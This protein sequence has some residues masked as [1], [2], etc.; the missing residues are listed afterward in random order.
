MANRKKY[1]WDK[2]HSEFTRSNIS[3]RDLAKKHDVRYSYLAQK[4]SKEK[5]FEQRDAVQ[6]QAREAVA[7]ELVR[8]AE[9]QNSQLSKIVCKDGEQHMKRSV[10][11]GDKLYTLFEAA[12]TAMT[13]GNLRE[14]RT[15]IDAWVVLDNQ[16]RK[17]HNIDEKADKPLVNINVLGAL[18]SREEMERSRSKA[19]VEVEVAASV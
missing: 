1:D 17:I 14:M 11:T 8:Q 7:E 4:S 13:Q 3:L 2:L 6:A 9:D 15:A 5:W 10:Q 18:P 12:V 19:T 16:M